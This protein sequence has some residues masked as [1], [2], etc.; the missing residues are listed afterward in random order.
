MFLKNIEELES[1]N[2]IPL[3]SFKFTE[4]QYRFL[5]SMYNTLYDKSSWLEEIDWT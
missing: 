2:K 4:N 5:L 3:I 1:D